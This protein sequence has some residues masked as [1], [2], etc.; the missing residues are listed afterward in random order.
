MLK[1]DVKLPPLPEIGH[2][3]SYYAREGLAAEKRG[4]IHSKEAFK[5]A[6]YITLALDPTLKWPQK[7]RYF[8]HAL[9]R[10][11]NPPHLPSD[12]VWSFYRDL[13]H[14]IREHAGREALRIASEEDDDYAERI[15][16]MGSTRERIAPDA[17]AFF[18]KI[19]E[20]TDLRPD[21]FTQEDWEQLNMIR[22]QWV[23]N[24]SGT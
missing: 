24:P 10:H 14:L 19:I 21:Y 8:E 1:P 18:A 23:G 9:R 11:C 7:V 17:E 6:Q 12:E 16:L 3:E 20:N 4:D 13:A 15:S 22:N 5:V 2:P